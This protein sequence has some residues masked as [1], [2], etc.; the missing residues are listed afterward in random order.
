MKVSAIICSVGRAEVLKDTVESLLRQSYPVGEIII[1]TPSSEN[2]AQATLSHAAVKLVLTPMGLTV[3]RNVCLSRVAPSS[4]LIAF[5]DDD[6]ELSP[7]YLAAMVA[8]FKRD[9]ELVASSGNL[10]YDGGIGKC[11]SRGRAKELCEET[12]IEWKENDAIRTLPRRFAYGCNMVYRASA[13][14]TIKFDEGLPLYGWLEDSDFSHAASKGRPA[15]VTN[16]EAY[17][18]HLGWRSGRI[19]GRR[20]GFSQIVNPFY[21][22]RKSR[23]FPLRQIAIHYWL[24][25]LVGNVLGLMFGEPIED[26]PGR[27]YGNCLGFVHLLRGKADPQHAMNIGS[28]PVKAGVGSRKLV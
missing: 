13:I 27:L 4:E 12:A 28:R 7:S 24:R 21:L 8:L 9:P 15:P 14:S 3:Q 10:L 16:C 25:C 5:F 11:I 22:W 26:R 19:A 6:M 2:I 17:A 20:L 1:G 18:V 23:V